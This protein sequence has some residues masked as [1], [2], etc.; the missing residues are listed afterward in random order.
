MADAREYQIYNWKKFE[1]VVKVEDDILDPHQL[2][3]V[4]HDQDTTPCQT[5]PLHCVWHEER[6]DNIRWHSRCWVLKA[7][8]LDKQY[9]SGPDR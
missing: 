1:F 8:R 7:Y 9:F 5:C 6:A 3:D 2:A 4:V